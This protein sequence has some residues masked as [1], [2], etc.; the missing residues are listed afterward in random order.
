MLL[1][2]NSQIILANIFQASKD[3]EPLNED[4]IRHTVLN[5]YRKYRVQFR[6]F[7]QMVICNDGS[8]YW[9]KK[10]FPYY[11]QN[12]RK[13]QEAKK[14]EWTEVYKVLDKIRDE[15][16]DYFPYPSVRVHGAE[17]DD[18]IYV[19]TKAYYQTEPILILSNDKDFQQLQIFPNVKQYSPWTKEFVACPDPRQF[20]FEQIIGGDSSDGIP[21][22][23]SDDDTFVTDGK[24]QTRMTQK[25]I[26]EL[27][28]AA[29]S[30]EFFENPKYIRNQTL[31]DLTAIPDDLQERI[32]EAYNGQQGKGRDKL[33]DYFM[34]HKLKN[35]LPSIEEF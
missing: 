17:A 6:D 18:V 3:G 20:L 21:N 24:R 32:L 9:R 27:Q 1:V 30:S 7:G 13:Q 19:L 15:V 28:K 26:A 25:R 34:E 5:T 22:I 16:K 29:E 2:D 14:D 12:R 23:L 11:K 10:F 35:L 4:Y 8:N 33:L 31:I